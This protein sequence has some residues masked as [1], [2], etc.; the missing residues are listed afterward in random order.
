MHHTWEK[1]NT[2]KILVR[3]LKGEYHAEDLVI[4]GRTIL[5]WILGEWGGKMQS[6]FIWFRIETSGGLL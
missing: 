6:G 4:D 5:E 1:R 2:Y 3:N